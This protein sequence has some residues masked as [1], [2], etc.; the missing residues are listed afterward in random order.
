MGTSDVTRV[1][2]AAFHSRGSSSCPIL[3]V[4]R[5]CAGVLVLVTVSPVS[6]QCLPASRSHPVEEMLPNSR[7]V[8]GRSCPSRPRRRTILTGQHR[9]GRLVPASEDAC[10]VRRTILLGNNGRPAG[11]ADAGRR[12]RQLVDRCAVHGQGVPWIR[13]FMPYARLAA[14]CSRKNVRVLH[15]VCPGLRVGELHVGSEKPCDPS[16]EKPPGRRSVSG[17]AGVAGVLVHGNPRTSSARP[18]ATVPA[19]FRASPPWTHPSPRDLK[20]DPREW[21]CRDCAGQRAV[22]HDQAVR[23]AS[24]ASM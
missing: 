7:N 13:S 8:S 22:L 18:R 19:V 24:W 5:A 11:C 20:S 9:A 6:R 12:V 17:A 23:P 3:T 10:R 2:T 4:R 14:R 1:E 15:L 16:A 21:S